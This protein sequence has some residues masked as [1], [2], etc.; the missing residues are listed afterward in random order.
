MYCCG[1]DGGGTKTALCAINADGGII[2]EFVEFRI[3]F[4]AE[5]LGLGLRGGNERVV[6]PDEFHRI[7]GDDRLGV[8]FRNRTCTDDAK[9]YFSFHLI[10]LV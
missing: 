5:L 1:W 6:E 9:S 4:D 2:Q 7:Q 3:V 8:L 10:S